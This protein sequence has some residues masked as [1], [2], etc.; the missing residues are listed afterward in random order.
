MS[1]EVVGEFLIDGLETPGEFTFY[2]CLITSFNP[3]ELLLYTV[4][5]ATIHQV[6]TMQATFKNVLFQP[7]IAD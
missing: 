5:K 4:K 6:T 2:Q 7:V 1:I 3:G